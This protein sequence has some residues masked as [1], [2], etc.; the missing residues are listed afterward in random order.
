MDTLDSQVARNVVSMNMC[1]CL[2][3]RDY[4]VDKVPA[5]VLVVL[6]G[7]WGGAVRRHWINS[8]SRVCMQSD[9]CREGM[10]VHELRRSFACTCLHVG[11]VR[12]GLVGITHASI[13]SHVMA[14]GWIA[15]ALPFKS[16]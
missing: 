15:I 9:Q 6:R 2:S 13:A 16:K 1:V 12:W 8:D 11:K 7:H 10:C 5:C 14:S 3:V 4:F